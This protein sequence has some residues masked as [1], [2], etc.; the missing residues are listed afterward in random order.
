MTG[1]THLLTLHSG[2]RARRTTTAAFVV[3]LALAAF[4]AI[5]QA[6]TLTTLYSFP[7]GPAGYLPT[8]PLLRDSAGNLYG[9]TFRGGDLACANGAGCGVVF[10]LDVNGN[11]SVLHAFTGGADGAYPT[12]T[13]VRDSAGNLYGTAESGGDLSCDGPSGCGTV[14]KLD[15]AGRLTV[16][17]TFTGGNDG[18]SPGGGVIR[19]AAGNLYGTTSFG[20]GASNGGTIFKLDPAGNETVL[21]RFGAKSQGRDPVAGLFRDATGNLFGTTYEG[22]TSYLTGFGTVFKLDSKG[23]ETVLHTFAPTGDGAY[24][25]AG[26]V[27]YGE[28]LYGMT[29]GGGAYQYGT[30]FKL[31]KSGNETLLYSFAGGT[32]GRYPNSSGLIH[33]GLGNLYSTTENGG[34][35]ND[36]GTVFELD[37]SGNE[38]VLHRFNGT[39]GTRPNAGVI[40]DSAGN[41]YGTTYQGGAFGNGTVF[42]IAP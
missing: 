14:F 40:R 29:T 8:S 37:Q 7:G 30:V 2:A 28:D 6:Q 19:D 32:D 35:A 17:Y 33:D 23:K 20:G 24:P 39:D 38:T 25:Y 5:A 4:S 1:T 22:G 9:E 3:L 10:K 11:E 34:D 31:D 42:K 36:D 26:V 15:P 21:F 16:L 41:L 18:S 13:L 12:G 27:P